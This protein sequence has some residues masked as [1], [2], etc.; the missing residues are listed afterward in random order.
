[1]F[2]LIFTTDFYK[3]LLLNFTIQVIADAFC[4]SNDRFGFFAD[5]LSSFNLYKK[6]Y[7]PNLENREEIVNLKSKLKFPNYV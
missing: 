5:F 4:G 7:I 1:M 2:V 3:F 6:V